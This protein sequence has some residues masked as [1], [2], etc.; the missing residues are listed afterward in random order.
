MYIG[1]LIVI[2]AIILGSIKQISE[3]DDTQKEM[4][5]LHKAYI[6]SKERIKKLQRL[7]AAVLLLEGVN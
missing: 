5:E 4:V 1:I 7:L 6:M 2:L 3:Y